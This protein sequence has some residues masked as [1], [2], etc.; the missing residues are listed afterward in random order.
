LEIGLTIVNATQDP[1]AIDFMDFDVA[2]PAIAEIQAMPVSWTCSEEKIAGKRKAR[3]MAAEKQQQI[4]AAPA[5]AALIK[6]QAKAGLEAGAKTS[7]V[8]PGKRPGG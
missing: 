2:L 4:Q 1:S 6:A 8:I 3:A 5:A 7:V